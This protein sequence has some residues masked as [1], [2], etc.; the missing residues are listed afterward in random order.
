MLLLLLIVSLDEGGLTSPE[1]ILVLVVSLLDVIFQLVVLELFLDPI[2]LLSLDLNSVL[3][4]LQI[5]RFRLL[6]RFQLQETKERLDCLRLDERHVEI[7]ANSTVFVKLGRL[8]HDFLIKLF[9]LL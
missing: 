8:K 9:L 6:I 3:V 7:F 1:F 5:Q 4:K 2:R